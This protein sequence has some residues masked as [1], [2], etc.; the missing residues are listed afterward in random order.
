METKNDAYMELASQKKVHPFRLERDMVLIDDIANSLA[1]QPR[2][3]GHLPKFYSVADHS[4]YVMRQAKKFLEHEN[5]P[6][7]LKHKILIRALLHD[8]AEAF[9]SDIPSPV[10]R[11]MTCVKEIE[12]EILRKLYHFYDAD[13]YNTYW[14]QASNKIIKDSDIMVLLGEKYDLTNSRTR[15]DYY[16]DSYDRCSFT[17]YPSYSW[18]TSKREFLCVFHQLT[19]WRYHGK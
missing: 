14:I 11:F 3:N 1:M 15:W 4:I 16:E 17:I 18:R 19:D 13:I 9:I 10:K 6:D 2:F 7:Y 8:A 12:D 5:F